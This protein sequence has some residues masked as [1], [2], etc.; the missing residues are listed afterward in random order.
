MREI[1]EYCL[2]LNKKIDNWGGEKFVRLELKLLGYPVQRIKYMEDGYHDSDTIYVF[3]KE[4]PYEIIQDM[5][6]FISNMYK[7]EIAID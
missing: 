2:C 3:I 4:I 7:V 6:D 5:T 1:N